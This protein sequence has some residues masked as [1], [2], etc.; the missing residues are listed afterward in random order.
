M[1]TG[2]LYLLDHPN[3]ISFDITHTGIEIF[4]IKGA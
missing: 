1:F 3:G 2:M 4:L